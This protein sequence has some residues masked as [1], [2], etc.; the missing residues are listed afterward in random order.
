M[1]LIIYIVKVFQVI[2]RWMINCYLFIIIYNYQY[3]YRNR[4][5]QFLKNEDNPNNCFS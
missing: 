3:M 5:Y 1:M 2:N 4:I